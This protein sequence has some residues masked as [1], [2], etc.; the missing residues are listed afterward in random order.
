MSFYS[1]L[2]FGK[3]GKPV[4]TPSMSLD[5]HTDVIPD[6]RKSRYGEW[7]QDYAYNVVKHKPVPFIY[8]D[9]GVLWEEKM[10]LDF[11][12]PKWYEDFEDIRDRIYSNITRFVLPFRLTDRDINSELHK[13]W[14]ELL[15][16]AIAN[17]AGPT[18]TVALWARSTTRLSQMR[19]ST[20]ATGKS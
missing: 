18:D 11:T 8:N 2:D 12:S 4:V 19:V 14:K 16:V 3:S 5:D 7:S 15:C 13:F 10:G 17:T 1:T 6:M 9:T 20:C